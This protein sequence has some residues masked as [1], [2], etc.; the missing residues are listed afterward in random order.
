MKYFTLIKYLIDKYEVITVKVFLLDLS[1][2]NFKLKHIL[3]NDG[4]LEDLYLF[5]GRYTVRN[6][7][8]SWI[9]LIINENESV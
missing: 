8:I 6:E 5:N 2:L 3:G 9:D 4:N 1:K 7:Y